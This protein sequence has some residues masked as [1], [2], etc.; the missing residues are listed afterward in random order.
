[1]DLLGSGLELENFT[2]ASPAFPGTSL[3]RGNPSNH[4]KH[5]ASQDCFLPVVVLLA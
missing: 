5:E 4:R 3:A 2:K 1:M